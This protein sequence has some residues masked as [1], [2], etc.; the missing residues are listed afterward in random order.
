MSQEITMRFGQTEV[1]AT[2]NDSETARA[3]AKGLPVTIRVSGTGI[4]LCGR[5]PSELPYEQRQVHR[6]WQDGDV[7]YNPGGGWFAVLFADEE[8][9]MRYGDQVNIGRVDGDLAVLRGLSGS[10]DLVIERR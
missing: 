2:L 4:D 10:Y 7:N 6:G 8:N 3:F 1:G 5:M 9:S